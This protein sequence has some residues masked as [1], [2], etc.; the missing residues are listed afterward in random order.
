[1]ADYAK[2]SVEQLEREIEKLMAKRAE[3]KAEMQAVNAVLDE[4][5]AKEAA[6]A[7]V[8]AMSDAEKAALAQALG[9]EG[10]PSA[11]AVGEPG[12]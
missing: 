7:Q 3:I 6:Q 9:A 8:E 1:M 12:G 2:M 11:E 4:K 10:I 5:R